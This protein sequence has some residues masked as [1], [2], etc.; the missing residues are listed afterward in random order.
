MNFNLQESIQRLGVDFA[1]ELVRDAR[2]AANYVFSRI[3]PPRDM[4][5][6]EVKSGRMTIRSTMA[7]MVG[8]D[9]NYPPTGIA[10]MSDFSSAT[11]KI[12]NTASLSEE[13]RR[14][15][16][17]L[18]QTL[19]FNG[20]DTA[21]AIDGTLL[22]FVDRILAQPHLDTQEWLAARACMGEIDWTFN[23]KRVVV[24]YGIPA[25]NIIPT[26]TGAEGY[27]GASSTFWED[28]RAARAAVKGLRLRMAHPDTIEMIVNNDAN[29]VRILSMDEATGNVTFGRVVGTNESLSVDPRDRVQFIAYG[30]EAEVLDPSNPGKTLAIPFLPPGV[31]LNFG[32]PAPA[33]FQVGAGAVGQGSNTD[34]NAGVALGYTHI[35]P[36]MEGQGRIGRWGRVYIPENMPMQIVGDAVTN[37]LPVI[38]TPEKIAIQRTV[39]A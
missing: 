9:D 24:N 31:I 11:I 15:L 5:G 21:G 25:E 27:G 2:P 16:L 4:P 22:N 18:V 12:A 29:K 35:A 32:R 14:Q 23:Q 19:A 37:L 13:V 28:S 7:G 1:Y 38:E 30:A 8:M 20:G 3:L 17:Q 39:M 36:T 6:F 33:G 10:D 34:E 26:A